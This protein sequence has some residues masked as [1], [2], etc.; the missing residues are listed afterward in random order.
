MCPEVAT[1]VFAV[2]GGPWLLSF[3]AASRTLKAVE[4]VRHPSG[5]GALGRGSPG[6][7]RLPDRLVF[8][9]ALGVQ[10]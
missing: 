3:D 5:N 10:P 1:A 8:G 7:G 9:A 2:G 4:R 6:S